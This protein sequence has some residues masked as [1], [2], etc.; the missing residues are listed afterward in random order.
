MSTTRTIMTPKN[1]IAIGLS[2]SIDFFK[3][4]G[5]K[6]TYNMP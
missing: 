2:L 5:I 6:I 4:R 1:I 3:R